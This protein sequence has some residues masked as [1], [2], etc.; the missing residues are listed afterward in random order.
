M[1]P[2][3]DEYAKYISVWNP[4]SIT[5]TIRS[6]KGKGVSTGVSQEFN[7]LYGTF[8]AAPSLTGNLETT[9]EG[10]MGVDFFGYQGGHSVVRSV[11]CRYFQV[12]EGS[13]D[14][15]MVNGILVPTASLHTMSL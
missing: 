8:R 10:D 14:K 11:N 3:V 5:S 15:Y 9:L 2:Q 7:A 4:D 6:L 13:S 12:K 1:L